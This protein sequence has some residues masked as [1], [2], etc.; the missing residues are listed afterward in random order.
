MKLQCKI[1]GLVWDTPALAAIPSHR[2]LGNKNTILSTIHP[3]MSDAVSYDALLATT[4][5]NQWRKLS[6][7]D[8]RLLSLALANATGLIN[9]AHPISA[10][11]RHLQIQEPQIEQI[12]IPLREIIS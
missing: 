2:I 4:N 5:A 12:I 6:K 3:I 9:W 8:K 1:S 7:Q 10:E 11:P